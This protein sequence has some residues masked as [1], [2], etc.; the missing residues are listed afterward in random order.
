MFVQINFIVENFIENW[1]ESVGNKTQISGIWFSL[2]IINKH[3]INMH[4]PTWYWNDNVEV[5][6][7]Y[8][9]NGVTQIYKIYFKKYSIMV[10]ILKIVGVPLLRYVVF[11]GMPFLQLHS[12]I[13]SAQRD[14][15]GNSCYIF[16]I[17]SVLPST[18]GI[19]DIYVPRQKICINTEQNT[20]TM[21]YWRHLVKR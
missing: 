18:V 16:R 15:T 20:T 4:L 13:N 8:G 7:T 17:V 10:W 19:T 1:Y 3:F 11:G 21:R 14:Y 2:F 6:L 9:Q 12:H 5:L